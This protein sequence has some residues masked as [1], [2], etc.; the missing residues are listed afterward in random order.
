MIN[1]DHHV[2]VPVSRYK[3]IVDAFKTMKVGDSFFLD[4]E[5]R[6]KLAARIWAIAQKL[7]MCSKIHQEDN[8]LRVWRIK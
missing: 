1:I 7:G 5:T 3:Y 2:P 8:G 4:G 6:Q